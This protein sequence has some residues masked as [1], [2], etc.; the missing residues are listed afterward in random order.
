MKIY[1]D[2]M[3]GNTEKFARKLQSKFN[4]EIERINEYTVPTEDYL[5][6]TFTI[7]FGNV[8][9]STKQFLERTKGMYLAGVC[10]SGNRNWGA[11]FAKSADVISKEYNVPVIHKFELQG[12]G[13]DV[14]FVGNYCYKENRI[15]V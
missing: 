10:A 6:I 15:V 5:L 9:E 3:T 7:G 13:R 11:N 8:P 1:Y 14:D 2:S 12:L 4:I